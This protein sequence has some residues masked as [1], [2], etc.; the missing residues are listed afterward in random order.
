[1]LVQ[2]LPQEE[3]MAHHKLKDSFPGDLEDLPGYGIRLQQ[4]LLCPE[5][6]KLR[7]NALQ[8][9]KRREMK[10]YWQELLSQDFS[11]KHQQ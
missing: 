6:F 9:Y 10:N 5:N 1:M 2:V 11:H 4:Q 3:Q 7:D 8:V